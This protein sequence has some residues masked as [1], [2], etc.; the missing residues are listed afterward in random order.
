MSRLFSLP[1][2]SPCECIV[3]L[4]HRGVS[5]ARRKHF[6][7]N[8]TAARVHSIVSDPTSARDLAQKVHSSSDRRSTRTPCRRTCCSRSGTGQQRH[9]FGNRDGSGRG[10]RQR[11]APQG[12]VAREGAS[13][14]SAPCAATCPQA[15]RSEASYRRCS[16]GSHPASSNRKR[17]WERSRSSV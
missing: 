2:V 10:A 8:E 1:K 12:L 4:A 13:G 14:V 16:A 15:V 6:R 5:D 7:N 9:H 11:R 17:L 3:T